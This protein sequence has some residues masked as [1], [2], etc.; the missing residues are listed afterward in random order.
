MR[1]TQPILT[2]TFYSIITLHLHEILR[3]LHSRKNFRFNVFC[4]AEGPST[5]ILG[6][7]TV[8]MRSIT[9]ATEKY[10]VSDVKQ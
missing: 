3:F 10:L 9:G 6:W 2:T 8:V 7:G 1:V 4:L 5:T